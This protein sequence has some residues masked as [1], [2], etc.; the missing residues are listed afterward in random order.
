MCFVVCQQDLRTRIILCIFNLFSS[1]DLVSRYVVDLR[2]HFFYNVLR[3]AGILRY[4]VLEI[5]DLVRV[6]L[7]WSTFFTHKSTGIA[8][9]LRLG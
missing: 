2:L 9:D 7:R 6:D 8:V 4:A 1:L 3:R 5:V